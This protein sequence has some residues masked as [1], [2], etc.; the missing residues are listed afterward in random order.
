MGTN[1]FTR[2]DRLLAKEPMAV[3][4]VL[5]VNT[6]GTSTV[7]TYAGGVMKVLG[8][9]VSVG[10]KAYIRDGEIRGEAPSLTYYELEI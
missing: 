2:F 6:D 3:V 9:G 10:S 5:A 4:T 8:T 1:L 7:E